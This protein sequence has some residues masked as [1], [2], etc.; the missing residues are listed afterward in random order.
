MPPKR[1][2]CGALDPVH[3]SVP[4][5]EEI[6]V[7]DKPNVQDYNDDTTDADDV[8]GHDAREVPVMPQRPILFLDEAEEADGAEL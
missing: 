4:T 6:N 5:M 1:H 2:T 3:L 7:T 8:Q